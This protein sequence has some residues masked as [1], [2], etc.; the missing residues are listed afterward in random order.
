M[1]IAIASDLHLEFG[2]I[3]LVNTQGADVLILSGDICVAHDL[4]A[5]DADAELT[6]S[7]RYHNF[8]QRCSAAFPEVIYVMGNHEHYHGDFVETQ[9]HLQSC[10][11][12]LENVHVL[13]KDSVDIGDVRFLGMTLWTDM[14]RGDPLTIYSI[15]DMM[16][17]FHV[18]KNSQ[19]KR[20]FKPQDAAYDHSIARAYIQETVATDPNRRYVVVAHHAPS[21]QSTHE[22]YRDQYHMN[23]GFVSNLEQFIL[24]RPQICL[25]THGHTHYPFDYEIGACRVVCNPRG[26][27][28]HEQ[29][30][31]DFELKFVEI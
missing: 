16:S 4:R 18:I 27:V 11:A 24:D 3:D 20:K 21:S 23:G 22:R 5:A 10:L 29:Q 8:F 12:Y 30:T 25:W 9:N 7:Q 2:D 31:Q 14:N 13:E 17:D 28:G 26:Y 6:K 19:M 1:K 15:R